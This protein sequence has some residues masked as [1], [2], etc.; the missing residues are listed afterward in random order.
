MITLS[1]IGIEINIF[2]LSFVGL[3]L[4]LLVVLLVALLVLVA[5]ILLLPVVKHARGD[6]I[7]AAELRGTALTAHEFF[8]HPAL[9]F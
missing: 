8:H 7:S 4:V 2:L 5:A 3:A 1:A 9:E 6:I